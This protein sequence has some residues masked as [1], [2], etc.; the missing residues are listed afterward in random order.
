MLQ[1]S[2]TPSEGDVPTY[3]AGQLR[4]EWAPGGGDVSGLQAQI[5]AINAQLL[6]LG[7]GTVADPSLVPSYGNTDGRGDRSASITVSLFPTGLLGF[8]TLGA[9]RLVD[10]AFFFDTYFATN[11]SPVGSWIKFDFGTPV[12][13]TEAKFYMNALGSPPTV[14]GTWQWEGSTDDTLFSPIGGTF[15]INT[16]NL[17]TE[18]DPGNPGD[19][20]NRLLLGTLSVNKFMWQQYRMTCV[21]GGWSAASSYIFEVE[22]KIDR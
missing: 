4:T 10:G 2:G 11:T 18:A 13:I 5:D 1:P 15:E 21:G 3:R 22:F 12:Y 7:A 14:F 9:D 16:D 20:S 8:G 19:G 6:A 17:V